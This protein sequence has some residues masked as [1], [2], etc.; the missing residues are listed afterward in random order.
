LP[1]KKINRTFWK[2]KLKSQSDSVNQV[3]LQ[4]RIKI[5]EDTCIEEKWQEQ[6]CQSFL[7]EISLKNN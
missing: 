5:K 2:N 7:M 4:K 1:N 3:S 6:N